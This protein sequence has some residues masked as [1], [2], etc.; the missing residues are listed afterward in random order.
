ML[1]TRAPRQL[2]TSVVAL[3][4]VALLAAPAAAQNGPNSGNAS[5]SGGM[6]FTNAYF[7]RGITQDDSG[8][9]MWP[10]AEVS[11]NLH[12]S[13]TSRVSLAFGSWNSLHTGDAGSDGPSGKLWYESDFYTT[14]G[15]G[16]GM[17]GANATYTAYT[18]PNSAFGTVKELSLGLS[19]DDSEALGAAALQPYLVI[20]RE[21]DGQA[22]GGENEGTYLE[23]GVGPGWGNDRVSLL[24][25]IK[26][27]MSLG[28]YYE[29]PGGDERFGYVSVG[30]R[31][32]VPLR[33]VPEVFGAWELSGGV[34]FL[35]LGTATEALYGE[36]SKVMGTFGISMS[37]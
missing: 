1:M 11:L 35:R 22:D 14:L 32:A 18:S 2:G 20:A 12:K 21:L 24:F 34:E 8:V 29:G 6:H 31:L 28:D 23:L 27:G 33:G 4:L 10:A 5:V 16:F 7:F 17:V 26:L 25:P 36:N 19:V 37:Y 13:D 9:I 15:L 3:G 30:A